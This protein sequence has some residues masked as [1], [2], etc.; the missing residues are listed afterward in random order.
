MRGWWATLIEE[1][2]SETKEKKNILCNLISIFERAATDGE[3]V[4]IIFQYVSISFSYIF[5]FNS[6][7]SILLFQIGSIEKQ[8]N[9]E[10]GKREK[11]ENYFALLKKKRNGKLEYGKSLLINDVKSI[12]TSTN[13]KKF[14]SYNFRLENIEMLMLP[15]MELH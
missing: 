9:Q 12:Q 8:W 2:K 4:W 10:E 15:L 7:F 1:K 3:A 6:L 13:K 5:F 14:F 11:Y